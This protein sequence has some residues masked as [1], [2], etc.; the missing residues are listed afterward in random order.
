MFIFQS[1]GKSQDLQISIGGVKKVVVFNNY[2]FS[3][4]S[5]EEAAAVR[6]NV[7]PQCGIFELTKA[8]SETVD[9]VEVDTV[10]VDQKGTTVKRGRPAGVKTARGARLSD[11]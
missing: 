7:G 1:V 5:E 11:T 4:N 9:G 2:R 10:V 6:K 8:P 3:T